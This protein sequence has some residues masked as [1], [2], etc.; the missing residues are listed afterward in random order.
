MKFALSPNRP[1][2]LDRVYRG[3]TLFSADLPSILVVD[4]TLPMYSGGGL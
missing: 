3:D 4:L 2:L 1:D